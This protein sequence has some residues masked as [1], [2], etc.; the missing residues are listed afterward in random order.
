MSTALQVELNTDLPINVDGPVIFDSTI[1]LSGNIQYNSTTGTITLNDPGQYKIDWWLGVQA[2][3]SANGTIFSI[4][5]SQGDTI[6]GNSP[7]KS[8]EIYGT[9]I[10]EIIN[11]PVTVSLVN[12]S[13]GTVYPSQVLP[14]K[15][16]LSI[17]MLDEPV[18]PKIG[19]II[20]YAN[21]YLYLSTTAQQEYFLDE[22]YYFVIPT[23]AELGNLL[24]SAELWG[25]DI[26]P[27]TTVTLGYNVYTAPFDAA[28]PTLISSG[29]FS[30]VITSDIPT[31]SF[32]TSSQP[33]NAF[34]T[35]GTRLAISIFFQISN[36]TAF[37]VTC[38]IYGG[39]SILPQ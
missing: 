28:T 35:E 8:D 38:N 25:F 29:N 12:N 36:A 7:L 23:N 39:L 20:P 31:D 24:L 22:N 32:L 13:E 3:I 21:N 19:T 4:E 1:Y 11:A 14:L 6:R 15:G 30:P 5:T 37:R 27:D 10:I 16:T 33:L 34:V 9:A 2:T 18:G 17:F 26:E